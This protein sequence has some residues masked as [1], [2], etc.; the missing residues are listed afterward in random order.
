M[1]TQSA[2]VTDL[3]ARIVKAAIDAMEASAGQDYTPNGRTTDGFDCSGFVTYV[4][5]QFLSEYRHM[6]TEHIATS[7]QFVKVVAYRAGDLIF[8]PAGKVPYAASHKDLRNYP[9]H[10]GIVVDHGHWISSQ[11][12]TGAAKVAINNLWWGSR[13][14]YFLSHIKL[15]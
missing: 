8:F 12:S 11:T 4:L 1:S 14:Y 9:S 13:S 6:D 7:K 3:R 15:Q 10:V 5:Q 2:P